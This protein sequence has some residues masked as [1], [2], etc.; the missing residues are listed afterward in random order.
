M[1]FS[2]LLTN[3]QEVSFG[4]INVAEAGSLIPALKAHLTKIYLPAI[5]AMSNWGELTGTPQGIHAQ[6]E[7][8]ESLDNFV[9]FIDG[10][11]IL[12]WIRTVLIMKDPDKIALLW[13]I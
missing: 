9:H 7:F 1:C 4:S 13:V 11:T 10:K 12:I 3:I 2:F 8:V 6:K 5:N